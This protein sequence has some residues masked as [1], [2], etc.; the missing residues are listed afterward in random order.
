MDLIRVENELKKR[1]NRPYKWGRKQ[2]DDWD[3]KTNFIYETYSYKTLLFRV[4]SFNEALQDYA[5][6]RWYNYWSAMAVENIFSA[7]DNVVANTNIYDKQIDFKINNI[8]FDHKTTIFPKGFNKNIDYAIKHKKELIQWLYD[9]QSQQGRKHLSN[10]LFI[11]LID[12]VSGEH[13]KMKA[14][15]QNLKVAIDNY[16]RTF[17]ASNLTELDFGKGTVYSDIIWLKKDKQ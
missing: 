12:S 4:A 13:W 11:V 5:L 7:N 3:K 1:W 6:N 9:N 8:P 2:Q 16:M 17:E 10:R 14:E 15:I